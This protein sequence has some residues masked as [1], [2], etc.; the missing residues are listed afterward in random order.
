VKFI[1]HEVGQIIEPDDPEAYYGI[2]LFRRAKIGK[3]P[4]LYIPIVTQAGIIQDFN[5][6]DVISFVAVGQKPDEVNKACQAAMPNT[7]QSMIVGWNNLGVTRPYTADDFLPVVRKH[8][9]TT[10]TP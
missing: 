3:R 6:D 5:P 8:L 9:P 4:Y 1:A 2:N 7:L 10:P